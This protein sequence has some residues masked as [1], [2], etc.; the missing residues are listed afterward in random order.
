M[1]RRTPVPPLVAVAVAIA[2]L[3]ALL[4]VTPASAAPGGFVPF[5]DQAAP[6]DLTAARE[7]A[8]ARSGEQAARIIG[9]TPVAPG[10]WP[11][12]VSLNLR[13]ELDGGS[14]YD[15][16]FCGGSL[17]D[18]RWVL[19]AAHCIDPEA[20][21]V[22]G[23]L[24][25][26]IAGRSRL[27]DAGGTVHR[28]GAVYVAEGWDPYR[29]HNDLALI[30][31]AD[32]AA[33]APVR[34]FGTGNDAAYPPVAGTTEAS[35]GVTVLGWGS[36]TSEPGQQRASDPLL[37]LDMPLW[38][39]GLCAV[40]PYWNA[41]TQVCAG[42]RAHD[43]G[44]D[45]C[46]GDS[47]GPLVRRAQDGS[48]RLLGIVSYGLTYCATPGAAGYYTWVPAFADALAGLVPSAAPIPDAAS[49]PAPAP[50]P[51][52][53][54]APEPS[55][56]PA[57]APVGPADRLAGASRYETAA[58]ISTDA[59]DPGVPVAFVATGENFPD[60]LGGGAAGGHE[61]GPVLLTAPDALPAATADEVARLRPGRIVVLGGTSA[62]SDAVAA[63]L[64]GHAPVQRIAGASR[65]ATAAAISAA[66]FPAG[67][68]PVAY[69][70]TG[71]NFPDAL[72]AAAVAGL[73]G[74][75]VLLTAP[76]ALPAETAAELA[77]LRPARIVI[78]GGPDAVSDT[79]LA[80]LV[81][82]APVARIAGDSRYGTAA[83]VSA[84][85]FAPG[86][87]VAYLAT[88]ANFPD[89]LGGGAAAG[90]LRGPVLL[91]AADVLPAETAAELARLRPA[92]IVILGGPDAISDT[93]A[94][95][96][97]QYQTAARRP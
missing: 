57:P 96:A 2:M 71:G 13:A 74:G 27:S 92:R 11:F 81:A 8:A 23:E 44:A 39:H 93:I 38:S 25:E 64:G 31:L 53:A 1:P 56:A 75:P 60:A 62:V 70:A 78:L 86:V 69:L 46:N 59:F 35:D 95:Q 14:D 73:Q 50:E 61:G 67:G 4:P 87:P 40:G 7:R 89:A 48:W 15:G 5:S 51:S 18:A 52:P 49:A 84:S 65:Y 90:A 45:S 66:T 17:I 82:R 6:A 41:A 10:A 79:V 3:G 54:P 83:R 16:H 19:T 63:E 76:D 55:P 97:R 85:A 28:L 37:S 36:T 47:G 72:G 43:P 68:T 80:D 34:L 24:I 77:R 42:P 9:G 33:V 88:G 22:P 58:R 12:T 30:E 32:P 94:E 20:G 29:L 26:V 91:T 21:G